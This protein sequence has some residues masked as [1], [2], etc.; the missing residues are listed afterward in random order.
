M[1]QW[2]LALTAPQLKEKQSLMQTDI[3]GIFDILSNL[4]QELAVLRDSW[5]GEAGETYCASFEKELLKAYE[6]AEKAGK[7][8]GGLTEA[9]RAFER[10]EAEIFSL[11]G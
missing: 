1:E 4:K 6:C 8:A 5:E 9:E 2:N 10:C 3:T 7:L 11:I